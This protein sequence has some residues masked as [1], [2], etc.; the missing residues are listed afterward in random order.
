[1][2]VSFCL[3]GCVIRLL[4]AEPYGS[5]VCKS[6]VLKNNPKPGVVAHAFDPSSLEAEV[7]RFL[8]SRPAWST[9]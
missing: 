9:K 4:P 7:G 2:G 6:V 3:P 5:F 8:S 1:V